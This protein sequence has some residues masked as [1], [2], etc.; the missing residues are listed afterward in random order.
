M[1]VSQSV[2]QLD[3]HESVRQSVSKS[4]SYTVISWSVSQTVISKS[5][6]LNFVPAHQTPAATFDTCSTIK[7]SVFFAPD[8]FWE[9]KNKHFQPIFVLF[10]SQLCAHFLFQENMNANL[11][12]T[13]N[14]ILNLS[15]GLAWTMEKVRSSSSISAFDSLHLLP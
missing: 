6:L 13:V 2:C 15:N 10:Y 14:A 4:A 1:V 12:F 8:G 11:T 3:G 7:T 9:E 5:F